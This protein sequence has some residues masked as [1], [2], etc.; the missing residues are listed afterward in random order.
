MSRPSRFRSTAKKLDFAHLAL[1]VSLLFFFLLLGILSSPCSEAQDSAPQVTDQESDGSEAASTSRDARTVE[2]VRKA[3]EKAN[4]KLSTKYDVNRIG[5]RRIGKGFNLYSLNRERELGQAMAVRIEMRTKFVKDNAVNDYIDRLG[6]K[7]VRNSD[8]EVP[9]TIKVVDSG[10]VSAF[11]LP[12]GYLYVDSGLIGAVDSEAELVGVM[13]HEIAHV[14][15]RHATR[16]Q[17]RQQL[18]STASIAM[19]LGGPIGFTIREVAGI[20]V[21]LWFQK[22]GRNAELEADLL[23][24]EYEYAAGY[25]PQA[26]IEFLE[27]ERSRETTMPKSVYKAQHHRLLNALSTH[28]MTAERIKRAQA[29]ISLLPARNEYIVDTA[30]FQE[31]KAKLSHLV[32][33]CGTS[34]DGMPTLHRSGSPC[35]NNE[36]SHDKPTLRRPKLEP[37]P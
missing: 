30:D 14:A 10:E 28:P 18:W 32:D 31:V 1:L 15:A 19:Y 21:P 25:D 33:E 8:A 20:G 27:K 3:S 12:G 37:N 26:F 7:I 4:Q 11:T 22:F 23:G 34:A 16:A 2:R 29:E 5:E 6:Q 13:A 36:K 24:I 35:K 17:T 9:F